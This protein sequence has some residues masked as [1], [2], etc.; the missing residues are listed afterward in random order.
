MIERQ[1]GDSLKIAWETTTTGRRPRCSEP[2]RGHN[3]A[4]YTSPRWTV[5]GVV[6]GEA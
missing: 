6:C 2:E 5:I 3:S 4:Q 1:L